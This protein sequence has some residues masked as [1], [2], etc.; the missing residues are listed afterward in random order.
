MENLAEALDA[1][2]EPSVEETP[3]AEPAD[4]LEAEVITEGEPQ[5]EALAEEVTEAEEV[6]EEIVEE[7]PE[8]ITFAEDIETPALVEQGKAILDKYEL[9]QDVQAYISTLETKAQVAP[10]AEY[11]VYGDT[12]AVRGL[13]ERQNYLDSVVE[14]GD[15][16][17]RPQTDKFVE[18]LASDP[19]K[20]S[21][22]RHDLLQLPSTKYTGLNGFQELIADGLAL[23][24][25]SYQDTINRYNDT[26]TAMRTGA[27]I[28]NDIPSF[29]PVNLQEA[30]SKYDKNERDQLA[31]LDINEEYDK[32]IILNKLA[33]LE[34]IQK[35]LDADKADAVRENQT[36]QTRIAEDQFRVVSTQQNFWNKFQEQFKTQYSSTVKYSD[37]P[38]IQAMEAEKDI[39][40]LTRILDTDANGEAARSTLAKA[41][42]KF[43]ATQATQFYKKVEKAAVA[44][45]RVPLN[46][47][48][49]PLDPTAH[50]KATKE[51]ETVTKDLLEFSGSILQQ[52]ARLV[53]TG[54]A[55]EVKDAVAKRKIET[56]AR[57]VP[58][59]RGTAAVR[60]DELPPIGSPD[61]LSVLADRIL[62]QDARKAR[63]YQ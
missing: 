21:W 42:I 58:N 32:D 26:V 35:G 19:I 57:Q 28:A 61:R 30:F 9:P 4:A 34:L 49:E 15:G 3:I 10:L 56:K 46:S 16:Q 25:E 47:Q 54:K 13:L 53:S 63:M 48:G 1:V 37:D 40:F 52:K 39:A 24:G 50:R 60:K 18:S 27:V 12:E 20:V 7:A 2:M 45:A 41:G 44:L 33:Q 43:D 11:S 5:E 59:G 23:D 17:Y 29:V 6:A 62:E 14:F 51:F 36:K 22:L 31:L 8:P 55:E 38:N